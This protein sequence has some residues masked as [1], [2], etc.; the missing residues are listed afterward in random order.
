MRPLRLEERSHRS[1]I[2]KGQIR[3]TGNRARGDDR[4]GQ[5]RATW[6]SSL[7][8]RSPIKRRGAGRSR[9]TA[10][11]PCQRQ[12]SQS[13]TRLRFNAG[14]SD[15]CSALRRSSRRARF[16]APGRPGRPVRTR[17]RDRPYP[18]RQGLAP[19]RVGRPPGSDR[20]T[21]RRGGQCGFQTLW[22]AEP[23]SHR[24]GRRPR[25]PV[26]SRPPPVER[27]RRPTR[28]AWGNARLQG[29]RPAAFPGASRRR[30][31]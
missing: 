31:L 21:R 29:I 26:G 28:V 10:R 2:P 20:K 3:P 6:R 1:P 8:Y 23:R 18:R 22:V 14:F 17:R 5:Q 25:S 19:I 7:T 13:K 15:K 11:S 16:M 12:P 24:T 4:Q 9:D 27:S 30:P